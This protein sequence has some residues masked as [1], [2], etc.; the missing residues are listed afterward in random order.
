[1]TKPLINWHE[2]LLHNASSSAQLSK[3]VQI[4][5]KV[6]QYV[7][8]KK[9]GVTNYQFMIMYQKAN[10]LVNLSPILLTGFPRGFV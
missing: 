10:R 2:F 7:I 4:E 1:M 9:T 8:D 3:E 6:G 5:G